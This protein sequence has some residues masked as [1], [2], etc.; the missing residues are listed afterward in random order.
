LAV[1]LTEERGG[2]SDTDRDEIAPGDHP[3]WFFSVGG[4]IHWLAGPG[5]K[6]P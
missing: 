4:D 1:I 6:I 5:G 3:R 2:I